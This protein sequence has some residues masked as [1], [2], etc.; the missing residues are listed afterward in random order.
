MNPSIPRFLT[1]ALS[2]TVAASSALARPPHVQDRARM[3]TPEAV[4]QADEVIAQV[5]EDYGISVLIET[6]AV[7]APS[8]F[9]GLIR[10]AWQRFFPQHTAGPSRRYRGERTI[11]VR[12]AREPAPGVVEIEVGADPQLQRSSPPSPRRSCTACCSVASKRRTRTGACTTAS[13]S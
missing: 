8:R 13:S 9:Q 11:Y 1:F 3:F 4:H 6:G 12:I 7:P 2:L 10:Q 5:Y